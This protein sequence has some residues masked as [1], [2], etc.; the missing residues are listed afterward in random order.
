MVSEDKNELSTVR[1]M[2]RQPLRQVLLLGVVTN[3]LVL[4]PT[5]YMLEVYS[6]VVYSRSENTLLMLTILVLGAYLLMESLGWVR[7]AILHHGGIILDA[8]LAPRLFEATFQQHLRKDKGQ[9]SQPLGDLRTVRNFLSSP[10]MVAL[11]DAPFA[12]IFLLLVYLID[13]LLGLSAMFGALVLVLMGSVTEHGTHAPLTEANQLSQQSLHYVNS[14]MR[15]AQ[16]IDS[17]GMFYRI[18][19]Q[20]NQTQ[21]QFL[22]QQAMASDYAG[23]GAAGSKLIQ[24]LQGSLLL[25]LGCWLT[26]EQDI[27][28]MGGMMIVA[29]ILGARALAPMALLIGQ[30]RQVVQASGVPPNRW[31]EIGGS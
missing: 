22:Q 13:P 17:M 23:L 14:V 1:A 21:Q 18:Y 20:W 4:A 16:V 7:S 8:R 3:L 10:G 5:G 31:T 11:F 6:R 24:T 26:L 12:L 9:S 25:G 27:D 15:N 2:I 30:W 28:P 29:S 19:H